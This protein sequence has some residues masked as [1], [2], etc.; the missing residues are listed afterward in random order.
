MFSVITTSYN[1]EKYIRETIESVLAQTYQDW[2][3][4]VVDDGSSDNSVKIIEEYCQKDSR[5]KLFTHE[6]HVNK[7]LAE[8]IKLGISKSNGEYICFLE[9]D[10]KFAPSALE[11]KHLAIE[12]YPD[13]ALYFNDVKFIGEN[14]IVDEFRES[15]Q[16]YFIEQKD[17]LFNGKADVKDFI[18]NNYFPTFSCI[19]VK[20]E[21]LE[22]LDFN[23]PSKPNLDWFLWVQI[24]ASNPNI[25][26]VN[27]KDTFWRIHKNSYISQRNKKNYANFFDCLHAFLYSGRLPWHEF[28]FSKRIHNR[29]IEKFFRTYI[30][31]YDEKIKQKYPQRINIETLTFNNFEKPIL[32]ICIPTYNRAKA[33]NNTLKSITGQKYFQETDD[34]EVIVSDN[35]SPDETYEVVKTFMDLYPEKVR[36]YKNEENITDRNFEKVL[37]YGK[38]LYLKL[39]ND[40][41][42]YH[43]NSL[44]NMCN[45]II[46]FAT[47]KPLLYFAAGFV[48]LDKKYDYCYKTDNFFNKASFSITA[49]G[50]FGIWKEDF[51]KINDF[52]RM[53]NK[54]LAQVDVLFRLTEK[55]STSVI[56]SPDYFHNIVYHNKGG[57][58]IAEVF[59]TNYLTIVQSQLEKGLISRK[60]YDR[61]KK[62]ILKHINHF[63]FDFE[64]LYN[65]EKTGYFKY[66][67]KFYYGNPYFYYRYVKLLPQIIKQHF[68]QMRLKKK[69]RQ[70]DIN[71]LWREKNKHNETTVSKTVKIDRLTV[72]NYSY[73]NI[74]MYH[75]GNGDE[76]LTIGNYC[77]I[78]PEVTF[79]LSTEHGYKNLSTYPFKGKLLGA[80]N[81]AVSKGSITVKDDVWI[82]YGATILSGVTI[83]QGAVIGA[84]SLVTKDVPPYAIVVG[85]PAKVLKYRF[86]EDVIE[87]LL[88]VDFSMLKK[89]SIKKLSEYLYC[90]I[91]PENADEIIAKI[92]QEK[93]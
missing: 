37:T 64:N 26:F 78:A 56:I 85:N 29:K 34:V 83:G 91:T 1:Y 50:N 5:I 68:H 9:S 81:E 80:E 25:V 46:K 42:L 28:K 62:K 23:C 69:L 13:A 71:F 52:S 54:N 87:K 48:N 61:E 22:K 18:K 7:G 21:N 30:K 74:N 19:T 93:Y 65:F 12:K 77:S 14:P 35:N 58:N 4:I 24:V 70:G 27:A 20:K 17:I 72:E 75:A 82:G 33:L 92:Q 45:D 89:E 44:E 15:H 67:M 57:Y 31:K 38:G 16:Q 73:G 84:G 49:I 55:K 43:E 51:D 10:D 90:E 3:L 86:S 79:L 6:N 8:T 88:T 39:C 66:L 59:G 41:I 47:N 76:K 40:T 63:Y 36:Y 60:T 53:A 32:S 11:H 2:E